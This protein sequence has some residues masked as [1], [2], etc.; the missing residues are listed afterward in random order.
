[1]RVRT[2]V[3]VCVCVCVSVSVSVCLPL[4]VVDVERANDLIFWWGS[5]FQQFNKGDLQLCLL[6]ALQRVLCEF[7]L[8][9][10]LQLACP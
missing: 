7:H 5:I 4:P 1:M 8:G 6:V 9:L 3:C 10:V 2:R